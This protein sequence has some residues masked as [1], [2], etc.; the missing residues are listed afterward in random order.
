MTKTSERKDRRRRQIVRLFKQQKG[1][2]HWCKRPM[3][4]PGTYVGVKGVR[5]PDDV[6]TLDHLD[7]RLNPLRGKLNGCVRRVAACAKCNGERASTE[8]AALPK[9]QLGE[10]SGSYPLDHPRG[11]DA[12]WDD[13]KPKAT[14]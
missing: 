11:Q 4:A 13:L 2:C 3:L 7:S 1:L 8:V 9:E 12:L 6:C 5:M 10:R 14:D